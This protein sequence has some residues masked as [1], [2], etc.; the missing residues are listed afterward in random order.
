VWGVID[1]RVSF[2]NK[3]S[4]RLRLGLQGIYI[5][6]IVKGINKDE[7]FSFQRRSLRIDKF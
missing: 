6:R 3:Y 1:V 4:N 5:L 2:L 7:I